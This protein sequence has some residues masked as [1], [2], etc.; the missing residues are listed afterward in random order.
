M[1]D[2]DRVRRSTAGNG[3]I[4]E[5]VARAFNEYI[6]EIAAILKVGDWVVVVN[7]DP[8]RDERAAASMNSLN[9]QQFAGVWLSDR[10]LDPKDP[11]MNDEL[12]S[13]VLIHEVLH[14][15]F[16]SMWHFVESMTDNELGKQARSLFQHVYREKMEVAI[17]QLSWAL[18]DY[19]PLFKF[20]PK[21]KR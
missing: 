15:H 5:Y 10:M 2:I 3:R 21:R 19:L 16:E 13:Q 18:V 12:R 9:G 7:D 1:T 14:L 17:D 8:P 20:P 4:P 11:H 6:L